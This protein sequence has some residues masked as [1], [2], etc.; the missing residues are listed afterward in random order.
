MIVA[1]RINNGTGR[2]EGFGDKLN[3]SCGCLSAV[4]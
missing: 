2:V 3:E 4:T 1:E